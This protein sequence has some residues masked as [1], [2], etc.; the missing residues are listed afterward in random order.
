MISTLLSLVLVLTPAPMANPIYEEIRLTDDLVIRAEYLPPAAKT[1][2][3]GMFLTVEDFII[4]SG[5]LEFSG[6][7]CISR[8]D[9]LSAS[10]TE[11]IDEM[12]ERCE[13]QYTS[14][15][16]ELAQYKSRVGELELNLKTERSWNS[17]YYWVTI[18]LSSVL[19]G[20]SVYIIVR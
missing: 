5:E 17:F 16:T 18:G 7:A 3:E 6:A 4:L 10:H 14:I 12:S 2:H 1:R 15:S 9:A 19:I 13:R 20:T 8:I 11:H